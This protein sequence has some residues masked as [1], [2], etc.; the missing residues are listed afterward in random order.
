MALPYR[1]IF[2]LRHIIV[3]S[4]FKDIAPTEWSSGN[5]SDIN[6]MDLLAARSRCIFLLC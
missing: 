6:L 4:Y 1:V 3:I 5:A 2:L